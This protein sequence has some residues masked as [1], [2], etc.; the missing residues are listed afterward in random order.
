MR[1]IYNYYKS[2]G[3]AT[4][5]MG[6]SFRST[7]EVEALAG[8]D[9]LTVSPALLDELAQDN[10]ELTRKLYPD[11]PVSDMHRTIDEKRFRWLMNADA[12]AT[13]K[14]A[15]G[16]RGFAQDMDTLLAMINRKLETQ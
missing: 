7:A 5:V 4:I 15:E 14:L 9:R 1:E 11:N 8:C 13:E 2:N 6:A 10:R 12:M 3:I 16:I